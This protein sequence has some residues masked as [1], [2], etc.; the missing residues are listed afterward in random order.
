VTVASVALWDEPSL[1]LTVKAVD[2]VRPFGRPLP[3]GARVPLTDATW[4]RIVLE[5]SEPVL[6]QSG[7]DPRLGFEREAEL[8]LL[9]EVRSMYLLPIRFAEDTVGVLVLG[10]ARAVER[11]CFSSGSAA[12]LPCSR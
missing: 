6:L 9:P 12:A 11:E 1:T 2:T 7:D 10:E 5:R 3:V 8:A 4:H